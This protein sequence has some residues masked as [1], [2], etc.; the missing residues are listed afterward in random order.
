VLLAR[1]QRRTPHPALPM[2]CLAKS[3]LKADGTARILILVTGPVKQ[4][5]TLINRALLTSC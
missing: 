2:R 5:A 4:K 1:Q 3:T